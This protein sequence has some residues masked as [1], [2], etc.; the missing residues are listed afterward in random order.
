MPDPGSVV[1]IYDSHEQAASAVQQ[2]RKGG[3]DVKKVSILGRDYHT[4]EQVVGYY[5]AGDRMRYWGKAGAFWG[6]LWGLLLGAGFFFVPGLGPVLVAG[7]VIASIVAALEGAV[8]T[9]GLSAIGA[10]LYSL[11]IPKDSVLKYEVGL[12]AGQFLLVVHGTEDEVAK[13]RD[14]LRTTT[15]T[16]LNVHQNQTAQ[17]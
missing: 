15:P 6:G 10:G 4:E 7:P 5:N 3:L 2:L 11:G 16:E 12:G 13:T 1:A 9:G 8:V 17:S 14:L